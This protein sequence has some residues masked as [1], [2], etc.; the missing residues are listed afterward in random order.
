M[1]ESKDANAMIRDLALRL[2]DLRQSNPRL[3]LRDEA[4]QLGVSEMLLLQADPKQKAWPLT[5]D[6]PSLLNRVALMGRVMALTRNDSVV[7]EHKGVYRNL[8]FNG[9][10]GLTVGDKI[11][12]RMFIRHWAFAFAVES[13][14]PDGKLRRSLQFFDKSGNAVHKIFL[15]AESDHQMFSQLVKESSDVSQHYRLPTELDP[16]LPAHVADGVNDELVPLDAF[17]QAWDTLRDVHDFQPMIRRFGLGREQALRLAGDER[18]RRVDATAWMQVLSIA[19]EEEVPIMIFAGNVGCI[20][21]HSGT[22]NRIV[23]MEDWFNVLDPDFNLHVRSTDIA[24]AWVIRRPTDDG[25]VTSLEMFNQQGQSLFTLFG[26]R[27]P[28]TPELP[29]WRAIV[30]SIEPE[31]NDLQLA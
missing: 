1:L 21:I 12:L 22:V 31:H 5:E 9:H 16:I 24:R 3:R 27:K 14:T 10:I 26:Q 17:W 2:D 4:A 29:Q 15:L 19:S 6:A 8:S 30:A 20:Q 13:E 11:N 25:V 23:Q 7:M 18:A 28:G